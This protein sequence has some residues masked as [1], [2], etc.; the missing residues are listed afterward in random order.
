MI[1]GEAA[2]C[3]LCVDLLEQ[4]LNQF[5]PQQAGPGGHKLVI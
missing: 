5:A 3:G 4:T 1:R 2:K